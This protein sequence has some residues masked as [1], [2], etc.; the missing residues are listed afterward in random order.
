MQ[1][2]ASL[3]YAVFQPNFRGSDG[4]GRTFA[5]SGYGE[6]GRKMQDDISDALAMLVEKKIADPARVCIVGASYGGYASLAGATFTPELYKCVVSISGTGNLADFLKSRRKAYGE[7]SDVYAYWM[8]QIGDPKRDAR[9]H[10]R[11]VAG[12]ARG[13]RQGTHPAGARRRR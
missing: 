11:R 9:A 13:P 7:E 10:C 3:G 1:Y 2:L 6:W 4:F 12:I 5:E 8:R